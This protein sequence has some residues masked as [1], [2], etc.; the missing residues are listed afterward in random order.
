M[1]RK[2]R[3][4]FQPMLM[5]EGG[6]YSLLSKRRNEKS[7][8]IIL[9]SCSWSETYLH[10]HTKI[11]EICNII[12]LWCSLI[13]MLLPSSH[14]AWEWGYLLPYCWDKHWHTD[15]TITDLIS[16]ILPLQQCRPFFSTSVP[17]SPWLHVASWIECFLAKL[18]S[19]RR[20]SDVNYIIVV[21]CSE[22]HG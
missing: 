19:F 14:M 18:I 20:K 10:L 1:I 5:S 9:I 13:P 15:I 21:S 3:T 2:T 17:L 11:V 16:H 12:F 7:K 8:H 22:L 4:T 6:L